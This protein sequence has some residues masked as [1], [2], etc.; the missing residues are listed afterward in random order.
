MSLLK[1]SRK[2]IPKTGLVTRMRQW[3]QART[4][5][6]GARRFFAREL[7]EALRIPP[8]HEREKARKTLEDFLTR[9]EVTFRFNKKRKRRHYLYNPV[10][11]KAQ[12]GEIKRRMLKCMYVSPVFAMTD[13]RRLAGIKDRHWIGRI[14]RYLLARGYLQQIGRRLCAH[15]AGAEKVYRVI[16]RDKFK[17]ELM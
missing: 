13:I 11:C 3:M 16:D 6:V 17:L 15:G 9:G 14:I 7:Y 4:G 5:S 10:W 2:K 8:G 12:K 1:T